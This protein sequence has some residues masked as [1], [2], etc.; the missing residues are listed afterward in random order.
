MSEPDLPEGLSSDASDAGTEVPD[1]ATVEARTVP[2]AR[3]QPAGRSALF[4]PLVAGV[5]FGVV[6]VAMVVAAAV[7]WYLVSR[8]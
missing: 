3:P 5:S 6:G 2:M 4:W 1:R 8:R 7:A